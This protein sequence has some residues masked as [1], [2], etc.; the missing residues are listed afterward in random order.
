M[1]RE[2]IRYLIL[3]ILVI[4]AVLFAGC[5]QAPKQE[6]VST[7]KNLPT[8]AHAERTPVAVETDIVQGTE[9]PEPVPTGE[10]TEQATVRSLTE[11][12]FIPF[13]GNG[14]SLKYPDRFTQIN[15]K[16]LEQMRTAAQ[17][18]GI[19]VITILTA[20]DSKDS[21]QVTKQNANA[22][23]EGMYNEKMAIAREVAVNGSATV[24][25]M[26]FVKYGAEKENLPDGTSVVKV[27]AENS[28]KGTAVT[29]LICVPDA[30]YNLN[31]IYDS[32]ERA[33]SQA[34]TRDQIVQTLQVS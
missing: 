7:P 2:S 31:F 18:S 1:K 29:Y 13:S 27:S 33:D 32:P 19:D 4:F 25:G 10:A 14:I 22:T 11:P 34:E 12:G 26:T 16:S 6:Q 24:K 8:T 5:T 15:D 17:Q 21:V 9:T 28:E 3:V 30:V 23:I 20:T